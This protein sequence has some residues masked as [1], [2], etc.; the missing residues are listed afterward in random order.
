MGNGKYE[1]SRT[2]SVVEESRV[3]G[4]ATAIEIPRLESEA[5]NR[6]AA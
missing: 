5:V 3:I 1:V 2:V 6:L 4:E